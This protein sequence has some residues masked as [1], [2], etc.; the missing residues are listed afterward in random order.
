MFENL[1][2]ID[3]SAFDQQYFRVAHG[4]NGAW[5]SLVTAI[6]TCDFDVTNFPFDEQYCPIIM[7]QW[8]SKEEDYKIGKHFSGELMYST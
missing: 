4:L 1:V 7:G 6:F 3:Y 5:S 8:A 2:E